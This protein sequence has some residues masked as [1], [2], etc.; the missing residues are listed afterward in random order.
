MV[1]IL[2]IQQVKLETDRGAYQPEGRL[3]GVG[4]MPSQEKVEQQLGDETVE[5]KYAPEW[6]HNA[7]R[8]SKYSMGDQVDMD[9]DK[10]E[11]KEVQQRRL[12]KKSQP[13]EKLVEVIEEIKKLMLRLAEAII[14]ED[15]NRRDPYI[16][17][18]KKQKRKKKQQQQHSWRG[19][20]GKLQKR[21]S[22][23]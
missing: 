3:E 12:H 6:K 5:L 18:G 23:P 8:G 22:D 7:T 20:G 13:L 15:L 19:A 9:I 21:I 4:D 17:A 14:K 11:E 1:Q 16:V 10:H 2:H